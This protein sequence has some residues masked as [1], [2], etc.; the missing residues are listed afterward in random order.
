MAA[1]LLDPLPPPLDEHLD[2]PRRRLARLEQQLAVVLARAAPRAPRVSEKQANGANRGFG[3]N[4]ALDGVGGTAYVPPR[5]TL[6]ENPAPPSGADVTSR[7]E[8]PDE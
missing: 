4:G 5:R 6:S 7:F 1:L 3:T 2:E 8:V